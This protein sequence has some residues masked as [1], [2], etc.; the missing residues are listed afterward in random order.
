MH[1]GVVWEGVDF[2]E[3]TREVVTLVRLVWGNLYLNSL[4]YVF[5]FVILVFVYRTKQIR[6]YIKS[7]FNNQIWL[8]IKAVSWD[9]ERAPTLVASILPF[10]NSIRVGIPRTP[11]LDGVA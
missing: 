11:Y 1:I 6:E 7:G 8:S 9:L 4:R 3:I 2:R 5:G 10:L